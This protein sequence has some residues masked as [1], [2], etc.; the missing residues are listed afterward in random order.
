MIRKLLIPAFA[1]LAIGSTAAQAEEH[2]WRTGDGFT[3]RLGD[4]DLDS[5]AGR[6]SLLRRLD[7]VATEICR[8]AG[9]R[10][11]RSTCVRAVQDQ[12]LASA[13]ARLRNIVAAARQ[14]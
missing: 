4:L 10:I 2:V 5:A 13:P 14:Q 8:D 9:A 3:I 6:T 1:L 11:R 12:A 7:H